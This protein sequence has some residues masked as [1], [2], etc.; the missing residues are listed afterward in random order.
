M[1]SN[2]HSPRLRASVTFVIRAPFEALAKKGHWAFVI[3]T[4]FAATTARPAPATPVAPATF[5]LIAINS[6]LSDVFYEP[7]PG[8]DPVPLTVRKSPTKDYPRPTAPTLEIFRLIPPPPDAPK[9]TKPTRQIVA[10]AKLGTNES[11]LVI[12]SQSGAD[13]FASLVVPDDA[14]THP[15]GT[16]RVVN[17]SKRPVGV[18]LDDTVTELASKSSKLLKIGAGQKIFKLRF[19][20]NGAGAWDG[21]WDQSIL[22]YPE[23]RTFAFIHDI[24]GVPEP[25]VKLRTERP[26]GFWQPTGTSR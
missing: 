15:A 8:K 11:S 18:A 7:A 2:P 24:P 25:Q 20:H 10:T 17:L 6:S 21:F 4:L 23:V 5:R 12:L 3:L 19:A 1:K 9:G 14:K 22:F 26:P 13:S 16:L